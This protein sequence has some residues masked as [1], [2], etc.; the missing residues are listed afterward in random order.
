M[1]PRRR[2]AQRLDLLPQARERPCAEEEGV[3][4]TP[5]TMRGR[6][7]LRSTVS[8]SLRDSCKGMGGKTRLPS[9]V[10][11]SPCRFPSS[12]N[13]RSFCRSRSHFT[14]RAASA[15]RRPS[16]GKSASC[17]GGRSR[18]R[19]SER[20]GRV[21]GRDWNYV[22]VLGGA[23]PTRA[24]RTPLRPRR[25]R[26]RGP[27]A[28]SLPGSSSGAPAHRG[29]EGSLQRCLSGTSG[30]AQSGHNKRQS[31]RVR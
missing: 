6:A 2:D 16:S 26:R 9:R 3:S 18:R 1:Q 19:I 25:P 28:S 12:S 10:P 5:R 13:S 17:G 15:S 22:L 24:V 30:T 23:R 21:E 20:G 29:A 11:G 14:S 7:S 8:F 31:G 4:S 27:A